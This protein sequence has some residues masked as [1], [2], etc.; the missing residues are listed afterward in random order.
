MPSS[1][2]RQSSSVIRPARSSAQYFQ[3]SVPEP[4]CS[5]FQLPRSIGPAGM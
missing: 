3:R 1:T 2:S 4:S 5:P